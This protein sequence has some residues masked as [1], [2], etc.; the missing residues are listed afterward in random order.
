MKITFW[1]QLLLFVS[2]TVVAGIGTAMLFTPIAFHASSGIV[3]GDNVSLMNE[4]RAMGAGLLGAGLFVVAGAFV[5]RLRFTAIVLTGLL[6]LSYGLGRL[7]SMNVD[8]V[9]HNILVSAMGVEIIIGG[10]CLAALIFGGKHQAA[11]A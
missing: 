6:N 11:Q 4:M 2:G 5:S 1:I 3:L 8:G 10:L 9:P 7:V